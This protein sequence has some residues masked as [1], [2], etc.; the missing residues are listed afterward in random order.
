MF[1]LMAFDTDFKPMRESVANFYYDFLD[2]STSFLYDKS[3][4][5]YIKKHNKLRFYLNSSFDENGKFSISPSL[6]ANIRLPKISK[7]LYLS[8]EKESKVTDNPNEKETPKTQEAKSSRIGLK[9]Y[10]QKDKDHSLFAKLGGRPTLSGNKIYI[11]GGIER[12]FRQKGQYFFSYLHRDYYF[13]DKINV[14]NFGINYNKTINKTF[15]FLQNNNIRYEDKQKSTLSNSFILEQYI[16]KKVN[17]TYWIS[18]YSIKDSSFKLNS[19]SYNFK[20]HRML[21]K[22][23]FIDVIPSLVKNFGQRSD[24][25]KYLYINFGLIF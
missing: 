6:R 9:Y 12:I 25:D 8:V 15:S 16:T 5:E 4:L 11:Q 2:T 17:Y 14:T 23:M 21:K 20:Y 1:K 10:F 7:H 13:K 22:W 3:N 19:L 18:L 24:F